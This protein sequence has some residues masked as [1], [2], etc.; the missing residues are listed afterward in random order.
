[1]WALHPDT[2]V[3]TTYVGTDI[4]DPVAVGNAAIDHRN[5][6]EARGQIGL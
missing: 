2:R 4:D 1:V 6:V 3:V 5:A